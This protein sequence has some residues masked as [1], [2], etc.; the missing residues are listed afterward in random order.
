MKLLHGF[1]VGQLCVSQS[2]ELLK[3]DE[4]GQR[5][6]VVEVA[7]EV[8]CEYRL[9]DVQKVEA[10]SEHRVGGRGHLSRQKV[11]EETVRGEVEQVFKVDALGRGH[12]GVVEVRLQGRRLVGKFLLSKGFCCTT[13]DEQM[14]TCENRELTFIKLGPV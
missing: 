11:D 6:G 14:E 5:V 1:I 2:R 4:K 7:K 12:E 8:E 3:Q 10:G 13:V 9:V